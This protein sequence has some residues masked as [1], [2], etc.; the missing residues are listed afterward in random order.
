MNPDYERPYQFEEQPPEHTTRFGKW[1]WFRWHS[2]E[3]IGGVA[4]FVYVG[5]ALAFCGSIAGLGWLWDHRH[6]VISGFIHGLIGGSI[7]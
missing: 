3:W 6:A 5:G 4:A 7:R 2:G 1:L